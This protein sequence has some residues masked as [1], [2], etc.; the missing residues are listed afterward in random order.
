MRLR[1]G[2]SRAKF[3]KEGGL[4]KGSFCRH[5][6]SKGEA[7]NIGRNGQFART[8]TTPDCH[9]SKCGTACDACG[10]DGEKEGA[11]FMRSPFLRACAHLKWNVHFP[12]RLVDCAWL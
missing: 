3:A 11:C 9:P 7:H 2:L 5:F 10:R 4:T 6:R 8:E 1:T 12:H